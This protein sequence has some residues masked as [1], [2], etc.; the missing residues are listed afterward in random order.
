MSIS[1]AIQDNLDGSATATIAGSDPGTTNTLHYATFNGWQSS[2][3]ATGATRLGDGTLTVSPGVGSWSWQVTGTAGGLAALSN[4][5]WQG[6]L[7]SSVAVHYQCLQ[8]IQAQI[9]ALNLDNIP[10]TN[11]VIKWLPRSLQDVDTKPAVLVCPAGI[12]TQPGSLTSTDDI[13]LGCA[14]IIVDN[15]NADYTAG[16]QQRLLWRQQIFRAFRHA[17]LPGVSTAITVDVE[18]KLVIDPTPFISANLFVT[19]FLIRP[20]SREPRGKG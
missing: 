2:A 9:Q 3:W 14:V 15:Q 6:L 1:L 13:G 4:L 18:P 19:G 5:V 17:R 11:V 16:L 20:L 10:S 7:N 12:E 8:A